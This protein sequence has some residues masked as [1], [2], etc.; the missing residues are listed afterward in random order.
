MTCLIAISSRQKGDKISRL[1]L[2]VKFETSRV[3]PSYRRSIKMLQLGQTDSFF[4][5]DVRPYIE[6]EGEVEIRWSHGAI[7][8]LLHYID[9][10][11]EFK[12]YNGEFDPNMCRSISFSAAD[13]SLLQSL[14][15]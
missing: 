14:V 3:S 4:D 5:Q 1:S 11:K 2:E 15:M 7:E 12:D 9:H 8:D 6:F 13:C 10:N